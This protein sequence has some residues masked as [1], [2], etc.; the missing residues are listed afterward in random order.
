[1]YICI[2]VYLYTLW[3][4][5][6]VH[7]IRWSQFTLGFFKWVRGFPKFRPRNTSH[8]SPLSVRGTHKLLFVS[9]K[10]KVTWLY[11]MKATFNIMEKCPDH[12]KPDEQSILIHFLHMVFQVC[13][14]LQIDACTICI[15]NVVRTLY[16]LLHL[17]DSSFI[18]FF[19]W[20]VT[21]ASLLSGR[22]CF[23]NELEAESM[24]LEWF[25]MSNWYF[26]FWGTRFGG[27]IYI[28]L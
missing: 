7:E 22:I 14:I 13:Y 18:H 1:M 24:Q 12:F 15:Y 25:I 9:S 23:S 10:S 16:F 11:L 20:F 5:H 8:I 2:Y 6:R 21:K 17:S 19:S 27:H 26:E 4:S 3:Y 28:P